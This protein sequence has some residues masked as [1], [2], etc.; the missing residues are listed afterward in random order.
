MDSKA[1]DDVDLRLLSTLGQRGRATWAELAQLLGLS[2][3]A[4]A[5]RA[6]K[7]E[8]RGVI[9]GYTV[10]LEPEALGF[11]LL[12]FV[13]VWL[14]GKAQKEGFLELV[15]TLSEVL[16]CH[17]I[18]GDSDYLLKVRC[19]NTKVLEELVSEKLKGSS[20]VARTRTTV[21]LSSSK[22]AVFTLQSHL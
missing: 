21:V 12:A 8:E 5:E 18:A 16:E 2:P 6:R 14:E 15:A 7:L 19:Q 20:A 17:H 1:L 4:V 10:L 11:G 13:E 22:E 9:R 3:P